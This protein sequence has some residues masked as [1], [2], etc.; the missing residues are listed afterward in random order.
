MPRRKR[1]CHA[2][3]RA[4]QHKSTRRSAR[5]LLFQLRL[6]HHDQGQQGYPQRLQ[7]QHVL[8][9]IVYS[10]DLL[11]NCSFTPRNAARRP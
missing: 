9:A 4:N 10:Q 7:A 3:V 1:L 2:H 5:V 6:D 11:S 8:M